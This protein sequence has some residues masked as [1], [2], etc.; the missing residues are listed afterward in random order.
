MSDPESR[1][2]PR[3]HPDE[4]V[5]VADAMTGKT[6]GRIGNLSESGMLLIG[7][8]LLVEDALYQVRFVLTDERGQH[9]PFEIGMQ[10]LWIDARGQGQAWMGFRFISVSPQQARGLHRWV[11][12]ETRQ[13]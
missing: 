4:T 3:R 11:Q 5:Q 9:T 8:D 6:I 1:R 2:A 7:D 10:L 12:D 13:P